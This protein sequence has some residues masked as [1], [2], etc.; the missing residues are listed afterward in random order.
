MS[1]KYRKPPSHKKVVY[2]EVIA[3]AMW[4]DRNDDPNSELPVGAITWF[5]IDYIST[6]DD[7]NLYLNPE[8]SVCPERN[9]HG[10]NFD[11]ACFELLHT[12]VKKIR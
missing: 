7:G 8:I 12:T 4:M 11:P 1:Y 5:S 10:W 6:D 2:A 3:P 9:R